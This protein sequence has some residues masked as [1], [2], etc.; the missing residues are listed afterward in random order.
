MCD[1]GPSDAT[2][3]A[4]RDAT[5][6]NA[7]DVLQRCQG[8]VDL[9][10]EKLCQNP[11][12]QIPQRLWCEEDQKDRVKNIQQKEIFYNLFSQILTA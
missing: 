2:I 8:K 7:I 12:P 10:L 9:A 4:T 3:T 6:L 5:T 1:G 11:M